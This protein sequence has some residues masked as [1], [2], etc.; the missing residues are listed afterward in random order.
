MGGR[1]FSLDAATKSVEKFHY[2]ESTGHFTI[3][4][5]QDVTDILDLNHAE[6]GNGTDRKAFQR[7]IGSVP[8]N[9]YWYWQMKWQKE[10]RSRRE[11]RKLWLKFLNDS[12]NKDFRT[13]EGVI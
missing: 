7:K 10:G 11:I 1:I 3:T 12:D 5:T 9:I 2:D 4:D 8:E 6:R 13:I